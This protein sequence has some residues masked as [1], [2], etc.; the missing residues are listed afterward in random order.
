MKPPP[1]P[2]CEVCG[3]FVAFGWRRCPRCVGFP[4]PAEIA[5]RAAEVRRTWSASERAKRVG[6]PQQHVVA[7]VLPDDLFR[8]PDL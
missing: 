4:S 5:D 2:R 3:V 1:R 8:P 6:C 7:P